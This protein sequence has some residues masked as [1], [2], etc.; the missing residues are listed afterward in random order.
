MDE[1]GNNSI[2][3]NDPKTNNFVTNSGAVSYTVE[4]PCADP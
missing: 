2:L 4:D 3:S 1:Q